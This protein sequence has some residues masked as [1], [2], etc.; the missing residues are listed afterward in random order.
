MGAS[1]SIPSMPNTVAVQSRLATLNK[2]QPGASLEEQRQPAVAAVNTADFKD[3]GNDYSLLPVCFGKAYNEPLGVNIDAVKKFEYMLYIGAEASRLAYC[4][5]GI[6]QQSLVKAFGMSPDILN[7]IITHYD[8]KSLGDKRRYMPDGKM[9]APVSYEL[10]A[11]T[12]ITNGGETPIARYIS[13]P[14]DTTCCIINPIATLKENYGNMIT[15]SDC[16]IVFKGSSSLRNWE[17]NV[18]SLFSGDLAD[19]IKTIQGLTTCPPGIKIAKSFVLPIVEIFENIIEAINIVKPNCKRLF[20]FGHSKGGAESELGGAMLS[21][22][23]GGKLPTLEQVHV[24]SFGAPK[25]IDPSSLNDYNQKFFTD[26]MGKLTLTR[27]ESRGR[28][29][30]DIVTGIPRGMAHP[31]WT[32]STN[33]LDQIRL[34]YAGLPLTKNKRNPATWPFKDGPTLWDKS[35]IGRTNP[36]LTKRVNEVLG[37]PVGTPEPPKDA[38]P[39]V[40]LG[41]E[42]SNYLLVQGSQHTLSSHM[43]ELG[44]FFKGS[45]RFF[46][47]KNPART[48]G[49]RKEVAGSNVNKIFVA[50]IFPTCTKHQYVPWNSLGSSTDL[51]TDSKQSLVN[52]VNT[53]SQGLASGINTLQQRAVTANQRIKSSLGI[54]GKKRRKT[55]RSKKGSRKQK[56]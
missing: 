39:E 52:T 27:V 4:D 28:L 50:N 44:M 49:D 51:L 24:I 8:W 31:G 10:T 36:D 46:G 18:R 41:G 56:R 3:T 13:S 22:C 30:G 42:A 37:L 5:V 26:N 43:E 9:L 45:Q 11:C 14:I 53:S 2:V 20:V 47:M 16:I 21:L 12:D 32:N 6:L 54:G 25:V 55:R 7:G 34:K 17:K 33:T 38:E 40:Q 48:S 1:S 19:S 15:D 29:V 23:I 35:M